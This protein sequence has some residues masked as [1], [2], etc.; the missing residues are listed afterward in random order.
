[1]KNNKINITLEAED[2]LGLQPYKKDTLEYDL[3]FIIDNGMSK[4]LEVQQK[5]ENTK[6]EFVSLFKECY[7]DIVNVIR[8]DKQKR[9]PVECF[10]CIR[11]MDLS[12]QYGKPK[13]K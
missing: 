1:M 2:L 3:N 7:D 10:T 9:I 5:H 8:Q 13:K 12:K 4:Y 6:K 11:G